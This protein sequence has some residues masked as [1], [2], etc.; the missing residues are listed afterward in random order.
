MRTEQRNIY[1]LQGLRWSRRDICESPNVIVENKGALEGDKRREG[2]K[3]FQ[4]M[5]GDTAEETKIK[6]REPPTTTS[7]HD[8][9]CQSQYFPSLSSP[10]S[11]NTPSLVALLSIH[12]TTPLVPFPG[13]LN[14]HVLPYPLVHLTLSL[15]RSFI[16]SS[17][18]PPSHTSP[19]ARKLNFSSSRG[20]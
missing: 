7:A 20:L 1:S 9:Y 15:L 14:L 18:L 6:K 10:H 12:S 5:D 3:K 17:L 8:I 2:Y 13:L 19:G 16:A 11:F 4:A